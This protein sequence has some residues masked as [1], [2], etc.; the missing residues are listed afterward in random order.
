MSNRYTRTGLTA[1]QIE[2][3]EKCQR[4]IETILSNRLGKQDSQDSLVA[5]KL[6]SHQIYNAIYYR[7]EWVE[8]D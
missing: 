3:L 7:N 2:T 1:R 6:A 5:L 4:K 8:L